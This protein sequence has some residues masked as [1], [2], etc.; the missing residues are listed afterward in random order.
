MYCNYGEKI[1]QRSDE[2]LNSGREIEAIKR[3]MLYRSASML[4]VP[5]SAVNENTIN[6]VQPCAS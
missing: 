2:G 4:W 6:S 5:S 1:Q 3:L